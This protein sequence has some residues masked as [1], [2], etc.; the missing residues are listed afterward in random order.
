MLD[1]NCSSPS[2]E[3]LREIAAKHPIHLA[4]SFNDELVKQIIY[5]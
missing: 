5:Q 2:M 3:P 1:I 4:L